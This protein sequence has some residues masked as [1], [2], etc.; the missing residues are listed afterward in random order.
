MQ[1]RRLKSAGL[2]IEVQG[3]AFRAQDWRGFRNEDCIL[4]SI[5]APLLYGNAHMM[6]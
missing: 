1:G 4:G 3:L 6:V 5:L 2:G